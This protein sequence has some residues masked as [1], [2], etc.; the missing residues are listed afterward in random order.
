MEGSVRGG[1]GEEKGGRGE[2]EDRKDSLFSARIEE[3]ATAERT[4]PL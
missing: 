4:V 2:E 1:A 3:A